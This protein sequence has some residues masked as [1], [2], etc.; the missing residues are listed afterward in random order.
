MSG[1]GE[2]ESELGIKRQVRTPFASFVYTC[3]QGMDWPEADI[4]LTGLKR[5]I[6]GLAMPTIEEIQRALCT[7]HGANFVP[8]LAG[9]KLGVA[10][11]VRGGL[12]PIN[13][14]RHPLTKDTNG[15]YIWAGEELSNEDDFF[16][17]LHVAHVG[18]WCPLAERFLGLPPGF[19]FLTTP[20]HT[21]VWFD[22]ALLKVE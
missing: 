17:P 4:H 12:L 9:S 7:A 8:A 13:G 18:E 16:V 20:D 19:R 10:R 21:D 15:W 2:L 1:R 3:L 11:N 6:G 22:E 5:A 14:L